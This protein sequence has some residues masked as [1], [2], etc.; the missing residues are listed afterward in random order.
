MPATAT[1]DMPVEKRVAQLER[2]LSAV[3]KRLQ[4]ETLRP[5]RQLAEADNAWPDS[6]SG[7]VAMMDRHSL[8]KRTRSGQ[9]K[10]EGSRRTTYVSM[11]DL[12]EKC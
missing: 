10:E 2:R 12:E 9:L 8:P 1:N 4:E 11:Y 5:V 6:Y 3:E 7:F